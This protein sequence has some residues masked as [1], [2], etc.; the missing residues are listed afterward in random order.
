MVIDGRGIR[1]RYSDEGVNGRDGVKHDVAANPLDLVNSLDEVNSHVSSNSKV[2]VKTLELENSA[3]FVK[4]V[5]SVKTDV[6]EVPS[7]RKE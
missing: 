2:Y 7:L 4:S 3:E 5:V 1:D 6:S